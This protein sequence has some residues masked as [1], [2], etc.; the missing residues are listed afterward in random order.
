MKIDSTAR[1]LAKDIA[2]Q[3]GAIKAVEAVTLA[4][5]MTSGYAESGSDIDLYV[6]A[7]EEVPVSER[8][9]IAQH[10]A[11]LELD[12]RFWEPGDE[13]IDS[14]T[15]VHVDV[16]Y[17]SP[18]WLEEQIERILVRQE[19]WVGYSTCFWQNVLTSD[20]LFDR[21][22]WFAALKAGADQPYPENL[23]S[24]IVAKNYPLLRDNISS[25]RQQIAKAIARG[26]LVSVNHRIAEFLASYFDILFAINRMP[27]PGEKRLLIHVL[28]TCPKRPNRCIDQVEGMLAL[29]ARPSDQLLLLLDKMVDDLDQLLADQR[30]LAQAER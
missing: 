26:D 18:Q 28:A 6:Y 12:N 19:A 10:A 7:H 3:F 23:R 16:M 14:A 22:G 24:A 29:A 17:R 15:G 2:L 11:R 1:T 13:W 27:H 8:E 25:Y 5:S 4:G 30:L 20:I 9:N 21:T